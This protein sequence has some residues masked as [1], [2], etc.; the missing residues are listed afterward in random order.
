M[1]RLKTI[2]NMWA[3]HWLCSGS[4][5]LSSR[6]TWKYRNFPKSTESWPGFTVFFGQSHPLIA[7]KMCKLGKKVWAQ[8][9]NSLTK[10]DV[11][12]F[13]VG[14]HVGHFV[15]HLVHLYVCHHNVFWQNSHIFP[16]FLD[17]SVITVIKSSYDSASDLD[18]NGRVSS[19]HV[20]SCRAFSIISL[21]SIGG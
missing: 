4:G 17:E 18:N 1:S 19:V 20:E 13:F 3:C 9:T 12:V 8:L 16:F 6:K 10:L 15:G 14:H 21:T 5:P 11:D 2:M 7:K